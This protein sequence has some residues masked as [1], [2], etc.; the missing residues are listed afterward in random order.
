[1]W[2]LGLRIGGKGAPPAAAAGKARLPERPGEANCVY[3][4]RTGA[5]GYGEGCRYN[6]PRDCAAA[7]SRPTTSSLRGGG[8]GAM[9]GREEM[10]AT[11]KGRRLN[12]RGQ[13]RGEREWMAWAIRGRVWGEGRD[14]RLR[15]IFTDLADGFDHLKR[16]SDDG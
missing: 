5:Y 1:M 15:F 7:V 13:R 11:G 8:L 9:R 14:L 2:K 10:G 6:H 16:I 4:L 12:P 3:Y